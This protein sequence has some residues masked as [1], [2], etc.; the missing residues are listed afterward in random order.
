MDNR[1]LKILEE[2]TAKICS[3][4]GEEDKIVYEKEPKKLIR[5]LVGLNQ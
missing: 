1:L 5:K 4:V 2:E 3:R